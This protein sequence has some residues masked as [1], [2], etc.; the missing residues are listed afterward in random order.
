MERWAV[1]RRKQELIRKHDEKGGMVGCWKLG[2]Q[3]GSMYV[4][5]NQSLSG[6]QLSATPR[7]VTHQSSL[8]MGFPQQEYWSG[9]PFP[10]PGDIPNPGM[11]PASPALQA[12]SLL[13]EPPGKSQYVYTEPHN[14]RDEVLCTEYLCPSP[15]IHMSES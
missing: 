6:V 11:E 12:D 10:S 7:T 5:C 4:V 3:Q 9:L 1:R 13:S 14:L 2:K 15:Q 8:S